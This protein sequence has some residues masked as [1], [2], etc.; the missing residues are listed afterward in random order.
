M[1]DYDSLCRHPAAFRSLSGM[2]RAAFDALYGVFEAAA[3]RRRRR[4]SL[5]TKRGGPRRRAATTGP[6]GR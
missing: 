6:G 1:F 5:T 4:E 2:G 3:A